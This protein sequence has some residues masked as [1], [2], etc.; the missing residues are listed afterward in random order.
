VSYFDFYLF[1]NDH[2]LNYLFALAF[3]L[4]VYFY[5]F[6]KTVISILD[7]LFLVLVASSFGS[8]VVL[9][10][11]YMNKIEGIN[12]Y[13]YLLTQGAL[14]FGFFL[15]RR[16]RFKDLCLSISAP[17][18]TLRHAR[19]LNLLFYITAILTISMQLITYAVVGIPLFLTSRLE[20][21]AVGGGFGIVNRILQISQPVS[22]YCTLYFMVTRIGGH[23]KEKVLSRIY[24]FIL[25]VFGLLSGARSFLLPMI[26]VFYSFLFLN[27]SECKHKVVQ[28]Y[29]EHGKRLIMFAIILM[30][31]AV[32]IADH[33]S[34]LRIAATV[35]GRV[36][37]YGDAYFLAYPNGIIEHVQ[38]TG[39]MNFVFGD[40]LRTLR[41][42]SSG[43][44]QQPIGFEIYNLANNTSNIL[45]GPNP[46]FN[47]IGYINWGFSGSIIFAFACGALL[48]WGR[49]L[50]YTA[51]PKTHSA[52]IIIMLLY[53]SA[54]NIEI[55]PPFSLSLMTNLL[56]MIAALL[57][58]EFI[59]ERFSMRHAAPCIAPSETG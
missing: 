25:I 16:T 7:P 44:P 27:R 45:N 39:L 55:D 3:S 11:Y 17:K 15:F 36:V 21:Y 47:I 20:T 37:S 48:S 2:I 42:V 40:L 50:F 22:I 51:R 59:L 13:N 33:F 58:L 29:A 5:L 38:A 43:F 23:K 49:N 52:K 26:Y 56:F 6:R 35:A 9:F 54:V 12:F 10:L 1:L 53:F 4:L 46:R 34:P 30:A 57:V 8:A 32:G 41:L 14:Y 28:F 18:V 19:T 31:L 24:L